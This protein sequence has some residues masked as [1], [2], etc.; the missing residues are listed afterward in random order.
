[1]LEDATVLYANVF[2]FFF[3]IRNFYFFF[4]NDKLSFL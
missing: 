4:R 2:F 3:C 1:M